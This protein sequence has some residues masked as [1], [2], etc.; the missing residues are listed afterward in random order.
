MEYKRQRNESIRQYT[1]EHPEE[2]LKSIA[3]LYGLSYQR[4]GSILQGEKYLKYKREYCAKRRENGEREL[5]TQRRLQIKVDVLTYYGNGKCACVICGE[6][7]LPCLSLDHVNNNGAS[8]R[9]EWF[10]KRTE[11]GIKIYRKLQIL[12]YP[13]GYQTLCMNCQWI[14]KFNKTQTKE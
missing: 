8:E 6:A 10:G 14:K 11:G 13:K 1:K 5:Y 7:R 2:N 4:I 9:R 3:E 12:N